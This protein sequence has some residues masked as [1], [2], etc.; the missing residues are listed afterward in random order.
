MA[1]CE[2]KKFICVFSVVIFCF[3][4]QGI[5]PANIMYGGMESDKTVFVT[6]TTNA[7][8]YTEINIATRKGTYSYGNIE[9]TWYTNNLDSVGPWW[10]RCSIVIPA[11]FGAS[12]TGT[13]SCTESSGETSSGADTISIDSNGVITRAGNT[14]FHCHLDSGL[15][16]AACTESDHGAI[17]TVMTKKGA[18]YTP[19]ELAGV[20]YINAIESPGPYWEKGTITIDEGGTFTLSSI[21]SIGEIGS[22]SGAWTLDSS[23]ASVTIT[24]PGQTCPAGQTCFE[25][26]VDAGKTLMA[27]TRSNGDPI[28]ETALIVLTKRADSYS[29][30]DMNATWYAHSLMTGSGA[31]W[32]SRGIVTP[33]GAA[34][35]S[36]TVTGTDY[37]GSGFTGSGF[38][39]VSAGEGVVMDVSGCDKPARRGTDYFNTILGAYN[40]SIASGQ[41]V[42]LR[43]EN[44]YEA[45]NLAGN[46]D[47][48]LKGGYACDY[49]SVS[50]RANII[51]KVTLSGA[52]VTM[53]GITIK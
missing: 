28:T 16:V 26:K 38:V 7:E 42:Q 39:E 22:F 53:D 50:G 37:S 10:N 11:G 8:G 34:D 5:A 47:V 35:G 18:S 3:A 21:N 27:C 33:T 20:W 13:S 19:A 46:Y 15:T 43:E 48:T 2:A 41:T 4:M 30:S 32:W 9:G 17:T 24:W 45:L 1:F 23:T 14:T 31:P 49:S 51:G 36:F 29:L 6:T 52:A 12:R 44:F 40:S 25:C